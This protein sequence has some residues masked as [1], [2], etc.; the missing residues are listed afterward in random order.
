MVEILNDFWCCC[1]KFDGC[2]L[3]EECQRYE[4]KGVEINF[5]EICGKSFNHVWFIQKTMEIVQQEQEQQKNE[6]DETSQTVKEK[7]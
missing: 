3:K 5:K 2:E 4:T 7:T 1:C 6:N